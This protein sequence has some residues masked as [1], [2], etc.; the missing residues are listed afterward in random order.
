MGIFVSLFQGIWGSIY[1]TSRDTVYCVQYFV[2]T[3]GAM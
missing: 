1:F 3:F 2:N